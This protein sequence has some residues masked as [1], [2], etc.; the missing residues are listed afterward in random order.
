MNFIDIHIK[1]TSEVG[2]RFTGDYGEPSGDKKHLAWDYVRQLHAM[3]C[4]P[5]LMAGDFN[6]FTSAQEREATR[7]QRSMHVFSSALGD[8]NLDD[9]G[10]NGELF[11][12]RRGRIRERLD[13]VVGNSA[14]ADQFPWLSNDQFDKSDQRP[15]VIDTGLQSR[16]QPRGP[17][18]P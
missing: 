18:G 6:D 13:R 12:W 10:Y 9:L 14:L 17:C 7:P 8:C 1:E 11:T 5:W 15:I 4:L 3:I 2:W 16:V